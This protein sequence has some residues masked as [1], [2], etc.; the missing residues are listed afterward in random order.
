MTRVQHRRA[1]ARGGELEDCLRACAVHSGKLVGSLDRRRTEL[2]E[3]LRKLLVVFSTTG[4]SAPAAAP[5]GGA[6]ALLK[7]AVKGTAAPAG[8]IPGDLL[9]AL[10]AVG[11]KAL[12]CGYGDELHLAL[13]IGDTVLAERKNSRAGW[14]LRARVLEAL[15]E[16][17]EA[18][19][20]YERYLEL[21]DEDGFGV[22]ARITGLRRAAERERELLALLQRQCPRAA[23]FARGPATDVWAE[24]LALHALGDWDAAEPRLVGALLALANDDAPVADRQELLSQ[25]LDL[26]TGVTGDPTALT[27]AVALYAEQRRIRMRGPVADP[28]VGG[29]EW[30]SLGEFRNR[31]AGKSICLIANSGRV[32]ESSMGAEIDGYD[33]VVRFN[34]YRIDPRHTGSRTD[35]HATIHKHGFNWDQPVTTRLVFGG[36]SGDW[37]HS[38]RNRLVPGAQRYLGDESLRWPVRTIGRLGNDLWSGIPT[39]GFNMLWLLD[40][41]DVSPTLDLIGFD[42]Y[43]SGAYRVQEAMKLAITSVHEYTSEKAWVMERAQSV[44]DMRISL[45]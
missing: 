20:A 41:L 5:A 35:I 45:R 33:L 24:G 39:T 12:E 42:F 34:S 15:G 38:L 29:V 28:T 27:E 14:R 19:G 21:T 11:N 36:V 23:D 31:I 6:A 43:E 30:I 32:G 25:Y 2:A 4:T 40:F 9:D 1:P 44:T 7:R 8:S 13:Q 22:A 3:Q 17:R 18:V 37:K 26:R 16:E 10:L